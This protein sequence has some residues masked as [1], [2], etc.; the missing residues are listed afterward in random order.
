M[1]II[2]FKD[3]NRA[4]ITHVLFNDNYSVLTI[5]IIIPVNINNYW[6]LYN[7]Y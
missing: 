7:V 6:Y 1:I 5:D 3:Y 4:T 2:L